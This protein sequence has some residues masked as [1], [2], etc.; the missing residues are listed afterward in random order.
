MKITTDIHRKAEAAWVNLHRQMW[1][2]LP[3]ALLSLKPHVYEVAGAL[4]MMM[5]KSDALAI[6]RVLGLGI[7]KP[8]NAKALDEIIALYEA[9]G[10]KRFCLFLSPGARASTAARI[11]QARG[12]TSIGNHIKLFRIVKEDVTLD[13]G[14]DVR[15]I[16][17]DD[18]I[19]FARLLCK[20]YGW[21]EKRV[22][23]IAGM[24]GVPGFEHF[25]A[26]EGHTPIATGMLYTN[27]RVGV[28]G[29]AATETRF[30]RGGAHTALIAARLVR[31]RELGLRWVTVET[32]EPVRGR[33]AGSFRNLVRCGFAPDEPTPCLLWQSGA[34]QVDACK[35]SRAG[36]HHQRE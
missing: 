12:L 16:G 31:A 11:L 29:W 33:P 34:M 35:H 17:R 20:H 5:E 26:F 13:H 7:S 10:L 30:R 32:T 36:S 4:V 8:A 3:D 9:A 22:S 15:R 6:N 27:G 19:D 28:L 18:A 24:V 14:V 21:P 23:W 2:K 1:R 25:L